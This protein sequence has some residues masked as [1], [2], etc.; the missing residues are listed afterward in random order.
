MFKYLIY[1]IINCGFIFQG[2]TQNATQVKTSNFIESKA[3]DEKIKSYLDFSI[4][5]ISVDSLHKNYQNFTVLDARE[6]SEYNVS[7]LPNAFYFGYKKPDYSIL[8]NL[9]NKKPVVLYCSIGYR[10]EE[11]AK[12]LR[13]KGFDVLN[14]YGSI[15]EWVNQGYP[16]EKNSNLSTKDIHGYDKNWSQWITNK[17]FNITY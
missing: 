13:A 12:K 4:P 9:D 10:S 1:I 17:S 14:L 15:F 6:K 5:I 3:F 7:H 11:M 8:Q 16:L 2:C